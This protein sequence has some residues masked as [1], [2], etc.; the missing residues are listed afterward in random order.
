MSVIA[1]DVTTG[2]ELPTVSKKFRLE[3]FKRGSEKTIHTDYEA[4]AK[5]GL[6]APVAIGPQVA[7]L[8]FRQLRLCFG[9]GW[10]VGG[11]YDITFRKPVFVTD[12]CVARGVVTKTEAEAGKLR[13]HCEVWIENQKAE[14]VIAGTASGLVTLESANG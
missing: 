5:E 9:K 11:K 7:A 2:H 14:K 3:D 12:F 8:T 6:P 10:I 1:A 4:A 13:V